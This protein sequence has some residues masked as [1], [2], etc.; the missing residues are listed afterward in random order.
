MALPSTLSYGR[1]PLSKRGGQESEEPTPPYKYVLKRVRLRISK[2]AV[3]GSKWGNFLTSV[4]HHF[5][6]VYIL[7]NIHLLV[8]VVAIGLAAYL[9]DFWL[10]T[11]LLQPQEVAKTTLN[12]LI[13]VGTGLLL[14]WAE[15]IRNDEG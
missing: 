13:T 11:G 15:K 9:A 6:A 12:A 5:F 10:R 4:L 14:L 2:L 7:P 1:V 3:K 8:G